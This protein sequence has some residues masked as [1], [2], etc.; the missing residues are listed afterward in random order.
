M[1]NSRLV[2]FVISILL[3]AGIYACGQ[4]DNGSNESGD[5]SV[6]SGSDSAVAYTPLA[7]G[8]LS[9]TSGDEAPIV[10]IAQFDAKPADFAGLIALEGK[11]AERFVDQFTFILVDCATEDGCGND[12]CSKATV[13]IRLT[14]DRYE[15]ELPA[16]S[17]NVIVIGKLALTATGYDFDVVEVRRGDDL[18]LRRRS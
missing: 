10:S 16:L 6:A 5:G 18:L 14:R 2:L 13:P 4:N 9:L 17:D 7:G 15:G 3:L 12:C 1:R 8:T 11:V